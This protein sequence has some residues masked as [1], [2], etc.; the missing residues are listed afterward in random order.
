MDRVQAGTA[1]SDTHAEYVISGVK[2]RSGDRRRVL[3]GRTKAVGSTPGVSI[4][5]C[6][7]SQNNV[8]AFTGLIDDIAPDGTAMRSFIFEFW[9]NG[10]IVFLEAQYPV[11]DAQMAVDAIWGNE[12][13]NYADGALTSMTFVGPMT[14]ENSKPTTRHR[15]ARRCGPLGFLCRR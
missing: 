14:L 5:K 2:H 12:S 15:R 7:G 1:T 6:G 13:K 4:R 10:Y 9:T 3:Q 8:V 11:A